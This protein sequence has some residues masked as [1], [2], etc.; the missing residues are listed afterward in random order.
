MTLM[1]IRGAVWVLTLWFVALPLMGRAQVLHA[2]IRGEVSG[3]ADSVYPNV[4]ILA[5]NE[6]TG[7]IRRTL[8][9]P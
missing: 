4:L 3:T 2:T 8:S 7:E 9:G 1:K 6:E 5:V